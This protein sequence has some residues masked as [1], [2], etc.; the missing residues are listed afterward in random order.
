M[1]AIATVEET[2]TEAAIAM[3]G[4][5][6]TAGVTD[7]AVAIAT[8]GVTAMGEVTAMGAGPVTAAGPRETD[9]VGVGAMVDLP[10]I[11]TVDLLAIGTEALPGAEAQLSGTGTGESA[12]ARVM[13]R[14]R[15]ADRL[16]LS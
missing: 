6:A 12:G 4:V 16:K 9:T 8:E 2:A 11:G 13:L 3:A 15:H 14:D 1:V 5:I 10:V 7:T